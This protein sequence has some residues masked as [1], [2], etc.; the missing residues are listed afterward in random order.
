M[1]ELID[2]INKLELIKKYKR[3]EK[4]IDSNEYYKNKM[5]KLFDFQKQMMNSKQYGLENNY[6]IYLQEYNDIKREFENDIL[7]EM[8]LDCLQEVN[9]FLE[10]ITNIITNT[11]NEKL[12]V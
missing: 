6:Y 10:I 5:R 9:Y 12:E 3:L 8:F 11:V 2:S 7:V 1:N 4:Q